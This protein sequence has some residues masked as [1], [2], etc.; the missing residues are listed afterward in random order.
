MKMLI[1]PITFASLALLTVYSQS[2]IPCAVMGFAQFVS[3]L[4]L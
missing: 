2:H 3:H 1:G 4:S